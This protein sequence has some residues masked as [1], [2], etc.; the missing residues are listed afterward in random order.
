MTLE[1]LVAPS[2]EPVSLSAARTYLRIG[3]DGDDSVLTSLLIAAREAF[4]ARTGR[5]LVTATMRQRFIGAR[6]TTLDLPGTLLPGRIPATTLVAA[7][8]ISSDGSELATPLGLVRLID[9]RF[10]VTA[11]L[12][13]NALGLSIDYQAGYGVTAASVPEAYKISILESVAD[14][15]VRRDNSG[16]GGNP[17]QTSPWEQSTREVKL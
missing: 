3:T 2:V 6:I 4:E 9:G 12:G 15:L 1:T 10:V 7:R 16:A 8:V 14:A 13:P 11:P 17:D 5:A